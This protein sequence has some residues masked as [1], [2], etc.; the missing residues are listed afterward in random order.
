M[1][2]E[3]KT[4]Q[5]QKNV[6]SPF[7]MNCW[8]VAALSTEV[9]GEELFHRT[10]LSKPVL[11]YRKMDGTPVAMLDRC[12]HRFAPLHV[13]KRAGDE[14]SCL[15]HAL[16]FDSEGQCTHNPHGKGSIP[17]TAK[18]PTFPLMEKYGFI[19]I[20]MGDEAADP[21]KLPDYSILTNGHP[22]SVGHTYMYVKAN[23]QVIVENLMDLSHVDYVHGEML[24]SRGC[25]AHAQADEVE[26]GSTNVKASWKWKQ[27]PALKIFSNFLHDPLGE[28]KQFVQVTWE[29][30]A[31]V[32]L[33][34]GA[35][36]HLRLDSELNFHNTTA[37][38]D[39]H[40]TT[41]ETEDSTH[42]FF[43][44]RRNHLEEDANFN[45]F[46]IEAMRDTF[47][48]E[49]VPLVES[50][51]AAMGTTDFF[52]LNPVLMIND[53]A[54]VKFRKTLSKLIEQEIS[55]SNQSNQSNQS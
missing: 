14:I 16:R 8:Y 24:S 2:A 28:A 9:K 38:Y 6:T 40:T 4:I 35:T 47:V 26:V 54:P 41:P 1:D 43:S 55:Q 27:T 52:S 15:Y 50:I 21:G 42:Y 3:V 12:P 23:Y 29:A 36:Q 31:H 37:Q 25:F 44:T 48:K 32:E 10:I 5:F 18:V 33:I 51:H 19:W 39:L 20:W 30:P 45:Q 17:K 49:D 22:N 53:I 13:G 34:V 7:L 46:K 11:I